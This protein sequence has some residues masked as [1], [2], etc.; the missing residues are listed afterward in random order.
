[1]L[2]R[3]E[4]GDGT[5]INGPHPSYTYTNAGN[6]IVKL[7]AFNNGGCIDSL[8]YPDTIKVYQTPT[9][10]FNSNIQIGCNPL[11]IDFNNTS[12]GLV[13][14]HY[15][16][17]FGNLDTSNLTSPSYTYSNSGVYSPM[18][19]VTNEG[20]CSDT[21]IMPNYI[22]VYDQIPPMPT[23]IS[24]VTVEN[25]TSVKITWPVSQEVD[26]THYYVYR[27]IGRAHV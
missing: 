25:N 23:S 5:I 20:G 21:V 22:T 11:Q 18:L 1:M 15:S 26:V 24:Y 3:S 19:I 2:F 8:I 27:Q 7:K 6:Y 9:A 4:M 14:S 10:S 16:W 13:N 12:T 17:S